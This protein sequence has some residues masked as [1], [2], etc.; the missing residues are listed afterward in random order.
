[1]EA[2]GDLGL[3]YAFTPYTG[4]GE[5]VSCERNVSS[6]CPGGEW[7]C[8]CFSPSADIT[9]A[10][11]VEESL[12]KTF[13]TNLE[14]LLPSWIQLEALGS[15]RIYHN[16]N[17][18][19][20]RLLDAEELL[21]MDECRGFYRVKSQDL[22]TY[23]VLV[24][25][26]DVGV[27]VG[28]DTLTHRPS[29]SD[30]FCVAVN[31]CDGAQSPVLISL[32]RGFPINELPAH[33]YLSSA[34]WNVEDV[35]G[36]I[37]NIGQEI[38]TVSKQPD[39]A[40]YGKLSYT[41][42]LGDSTVELSFEGLVGLESDSLVQLL[43]TDQIPEFSGFMTGKTYLTLNSSGQLIQLQGIV[44][45]TDIKYSGSNVPSE[46]CSSHHSLKVTLSQ[47]S[48]TDQNNIFNSLL[49]DGGQFSCPTEVE[50]KMSA[51][52]QLYDII[53]TTSCRDLTLGNFVLG[54]MYHKLYLLH[55][56]SEVLRCSGI[57]LPNHDQ[58]Q[59]ALVSR[60]KESGD[61]P[62]SW[63]LDLNGDK[64]QTSI[65]TMID[66]L[67]KSFSAGTIGNV[68]VLKLFGNP[69]PV[70]LSISESKMEFELEME[71]LDT[72]SQVTG[73]ATAEG[74][75][76][77]PV[78]R[79]HGNLER[80]TVWE[81]ME[82]AASNFL[83]KESER[84]PKLLYTSQLSLMAA[85]NLTT[86]LWN[87][88][89]ASG[90]WQQGA[91][92]RYTEAKKAR[93]HAEINYE[94]HSVQ[95][96]LNGQRWQSTELVRTLNQLCSMVDNCASN[97]YS[98]I[99]CGKCDKMAVPFTRRWYGSSTCSRKANKAVSREEYVVKHRLTEVEGPEVG[100]LSCDQS[101][102][103]YWEDA[104]FGCSV[105][106]KTEGVRSIF[107]QSNRS[108]E[109]VDYV[110]ESTSYACN[111]PLMEDAKWQMDHFCCG[112]E[113]DTT[114]HSANCLS[115]NIG[116]RLGRELVL[117]ALGD[118][119][120]E[121]ATNLYSTLDDLLK[122]RILADMNESVAIETLRSA[123][124]ISGLH[125]YF[126]LQASE[127][128]ELREARD[129]AFQ[130]RYKE[131]DNTTEHSISIEN[132][133]FNLTL[134]SKP[135]TTIPLEVM[136]SVNNCSN[137]SLVFDFLVSSV[138]S[139]IIAG[140]NQLAKRAVEGN[141]PHSFSSATDYGTY[142]KLFQDVASFF[143]ILNQSV[144]ESINHYSNASDSA[145][146]IAGNLDDKVQ[147]L[148]DWRVPTVW[149]NT[150]ADGLV[151]LGGIQRMIEE[152]E[153]LQ[154]Y[155]DLVDNMSAAARKSIRTAKQ[156]VFTKWL[157]Y[158][159]EN[160]GVVMQGY[161][162][163]G[164][165][166][167]MLKLSELVEELLLLPGSDWSKNMLS[168]LEEAT[169]E[170]LSMV[171]DDSIRSMDTMQAKCGRM[172]RIV[173][174]MLERDYW[175]QLTP[176]VD[177]EMSRESPV[178]AGSGEVTLSCSS[179]S[180]FKVHYQWLKDGVA[181]PGETSS[182]LLIPEVTLES[183]GAYSCSV[184]THKGEDI[185][186]TVSLVV[187]QAPQ[188]TVAAAN[189]TVFP[190]EGTVFLRC[191]S[192]GSPTPGWN[193]YF[194]SPL[195]SSPEELEGETRSELVID[196][197]GADREG[198]YYCEASNV[199]GV[200]RASPGAY[201]RVLESKPSVQGKMCEVHFS[202]NTRQ[203]RASNDLLKDYVA[204]SPDEEDSV[205]SY[206]L[207]ELLIHSVFSNSSTVVVKEGQITVE[208]I[209]K[210]IKLT[211]LLV[212]E[213][214]K[215]SMDQ[216]IEETLHQL[217]L[218]R[219]EWQMVVDI[220]SDHIDNETAYDYSSLG[221]DYGNITSASVQEGALF[222]R[223]PEGYE[224]ERDSKLFC[225]SC[226]PGS[227]QTYSVELLSSTVSLTYPSCKLCPLGH[228]QPNPGQSQCLPCPLGHHLSSL[229]GTECTPCTPGTH[230]P[231]M[232]QVECALCPIGHYQQNNGQ[233][234]CDPCPLGQNQSAI[235]QLSCRICPDSHYQDEDG[236]STCKSCPRGYIYNSTVLG[237]AIDVKNC[238]CV[239]NC[240]VDVD[241]YWV[242]WMPIL[243]AVFAGL[244]LLIVIACI[245][246]CVRSKTV[247][248]AR[249]RDIWKYESQLEMSFSSAFMRRNE[250]H[251]DF[252]DGS[253]SD[254]ENVLA[255]SK[256][257][258]NNPLFANEDL[259]NGN[260][261]FEFQQGK[262][263]DWAFRNANFEETDFGFNPKPMSKDQDS[264]DSDDEK[265]DLLP[266]EEND[267]NAAKDHW[268][269]VAVLI[270][271]WEKT[272]KEAG[273][274][275]YKNQPRKPPP[276]YQDASD[277]EDFSTDSDEDTDEESGSEDSD[278]TS[279]EES[280]EGSLVD[281]KEEV[282][283]N[284][285]DD[286]GGSETESERSEESEEDPETC[287]N[288]V[289]L[290]RVEPAEKGQ[291][292][293]ETGDIEDDTAV[294]V[295]W[296][297]NPMIEA[298]VITNPNLSAIDD[299]VGEMMKSLGQLED[300]AGTTPS[301]P[302]PKETPSPAVKQASSYIKPPS[303]ANPVLPKLSAP[304][305][306]RAKGG[307]SSLIGKWEQVS[308]TTDRKDKDKD[309]DEENLL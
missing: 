251:M 72:I 207:T 252:E 60:L 292:L 113:T 199:V 4:D 192:T 194:E 139:S 225:V 142:C 271:E 71:V 265:Q 14:D 21:T 125:N 160:I 279:T 171:W 35:F 120:P 183:E 213:I 267:E 191:N 51:S 143:G 108:E 293:S 231:L 67:K 110:T 198:W 80:G 209:T 93:Q 149:R 5:C 259:G 260:P 30:A 165:V 105:I 258:Y 132:I 283:E 8:T 270:D 301:P 28:N 229:G 196:P 56:T 217:T 130:N 43:S 170:I 61:V 83:D 298:E 206:N 220:V 201:L 203:K 210:N 179:T 87:L 155:Q 303:P 65:L 6:S 115:W 126:H 232:G 27:T 29:G 166:E 248:K 131:I 107:V 123:E 222:S 264:S 263:G 63:F 124:K 97:L 256:Y 178:V 141:C 45:T 168:D 34:N 104:S 2:S 163:S 237:G 53:F 121:E 275:L 90:E 3:S 240:A 305:K 300:I 24:Y 11:L 18:Y 228:Y 103:N 276:V 254:W 169:D 226:P 223:C 184:Q 274:S 42:S 154:A 297:V 262:G 182:S 214:L 187:H 106:Y 137:N 40:I 236:Q 186:S 299:V 117:E 37:V 308:S 250:G 195:S 118:S 244:C 277:Q 64:D 172:E 136:Y 150:T 39:V 205:L 134:D 272:A 173:G 239:E 273:P 218:S 268:N 249:V 17:S 306:R 200:T 59:L 153:E 269:R 84:A 245:L 112:L 188:L 32:P 159:E 73:V 286:K 26:G 13:L 204:I 238:S 1:M 58:H 74:P 280:E 36:L 202:P 285:D 291:P 234:T 181:L 162:C 221:V 15:G 211:F 62:F 38:E 219:M 261:V 147:L 284:S 54:G 91:D 128:V 7:N 287:D 296:S 227:Y 96:V 230:Q 215:K 78:L 288:S 189:V 138:Q 242:I 75:N 294:P 98:S 111:S 278:A 282:S 266:K 224:L 20:T 208:D 161:N 82:V 145:E 94:G 116:C 55:S 180:K 86:H 152:T 289:Q 77:T 167:C 140:A 148:R 95:V 25:Y 241:L 253:R 164:M 151:D 257:M 47:W 146:W 50:M 23:A 22:G 31:L 197:P 102:A 307:L 46:P 19:T 89:T 16:D 76:T 57:S 246:R 101:Q 309:K 109:F 69:V 122:E 255:D 302:P 70:E 144:W 216:T 247:K 12:A 92:S 68:A 129:A 88:K 135:P 52:G 119:T 157:L 304:G 44:A 185:S 99:V 66:P 100:I 127:L 212:S 48:V 85:Q 233:P 114:I 10:Y 156:Y 281:G 9:A 49:S 235:G 193:W 133:F 41:G 33:M 295:E 190:E 79:I 176:E 158:M 290:L 243:V 175:C 174:E 81:D 177:V